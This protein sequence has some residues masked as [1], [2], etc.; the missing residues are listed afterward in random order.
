MVLL[1]VALMVPGYYWW[2][3]MVRAQR[4][5]Q[6]SPAPFPTVLSSE[7]LSSSSNFSSSLQTSWRPP[8]LTE[9]PNLDLQKSILSSLFGADCLNTVQGKGLLTDNY[10]AVCH[11]HDIN[12]EGCCVQYI[13]RYSCKTCRSDV[14]CCESY[15][16]CVSC[17]VT[18]RLPEG[19][20]SV[21][22]E[23]FSNCVRDCRTSSHST[24]HGNEYKHKLTHCYDPKEQSLEQLVLGPNATKTLALE[25]PSISCKEACAALEPSHTCSEELMVPLNQC[26]MLRQHFPCE[27]GCKFDKG[28]D[29]PSYVNRSTDTK[30]GP[31]VCLVNE[32]TSGID[33]NGRNPA[34]QRLCRCLAP[35]ALR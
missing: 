8:D 22:V 10:G 34:T 9:K 18:K 17:C 35:D 26:H 20:V 21:S 7:L 31:G 11:R 25:K 15:E 27:A 23:I 13:D 12:K 4:T 19:Q 28:A 29:S 24:R 3:I 33:C 5:K 14:K 16:Y 6:P 2:G 1:I 32:K 30:Y